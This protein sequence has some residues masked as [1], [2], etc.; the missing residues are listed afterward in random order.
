M[1]QKIKVRLGELGAIEMPSSG[2]VK[3]T[4]N[5]PEDFDLVGKVVYFSLRSKAGTFK[6]NSGDGDGIAINGQALGIDI[7]PTETSGDLTLA[8]FQAG[9]TQF[10]IDISDPV[11]LRF[12]GSIEWTDF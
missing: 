4:L 5:M 9:I 10:K 6:R 2:P 7:L 11:E 8:D 3:I 1:A 12:T